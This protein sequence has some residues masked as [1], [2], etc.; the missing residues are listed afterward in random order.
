MTDGGREKVLRQA[1]VRGKESGCCSLAEAGTGK[2]ASLGIAPFLDEN[3]ADRSESP[4]ALS[5]CMNRTDP[6][7]KRRTTAG[8][9]FTSSRPLLHPPK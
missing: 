9:L 4:P 8:K 1:H 3:D 5:V 6:R 2:E 7:D